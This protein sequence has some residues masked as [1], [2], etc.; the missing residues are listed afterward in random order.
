MSK[1][2]VIGK[3]RIKGIAYHCHYFEDE[4]YAVAEKTGLTLDLVKKSVVLVQIQ[5]NRLRKGLRRALIGSLERVVVG[6]EESSTRI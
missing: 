2:T 6:N 3:Y 5:K 4:K 1:P